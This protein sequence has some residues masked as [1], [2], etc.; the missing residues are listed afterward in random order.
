MR[1]RCNPADQGE[2]ELQGTRGL[3]ETEKTCGLDTAQWV[4]I[5]H[6]TVNIFVIGVGKK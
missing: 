5:V 4:F 2:I 1:S 3:L 6:I